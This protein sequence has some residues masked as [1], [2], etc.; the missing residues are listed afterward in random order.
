MTADATR[1]LVLDLGHRPAFSRDDFLV[2]NCNAVA[3]GWVDR[4]PD[5]PD[6]MTGLNLTGS[7]ACGKTHLAAA[8]CLRSAAAWIDTG[9]TSFAAAAGA[10]GRSVH[11]VIDGFDE[12]WA[13]EPI[14]HLYNMVR[15]RR[16]TLMLS[17]VEPVTRLRC[18]PPDLASRLATLTS[19]PIGKPDD[20]LLAGVLSK[21]LFDRQMQVGER[22][23]YYLVSRMERSFAEAA[24]LVRLLDETSL[25]TGR[26]V[27]LPL[28]REVLAARGAENTS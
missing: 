28:V 4:W 15:E 12:T 1:Q 21:L 25:A 9:P 23:L 11:A 20:V 13:G 3:V 6:G 18:Q 17:S 8:W 24:T 2:S 14:L 27:T 7:P 16:G 5:W 22:I 26:P 10:L 19:I